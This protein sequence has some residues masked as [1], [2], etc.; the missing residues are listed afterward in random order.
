[1]TTADWPCEA[2]GPEALEHGARCFFAELER[3]VCDSREECHGALAIERRR[4]FDRIQQLAAAGDDVGLVL[5][6]EFTDPEQLLGGS[7]DLS[8]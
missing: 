1:V 4:V 6:A 7:E 3:R 8:P 5:A 2:Y